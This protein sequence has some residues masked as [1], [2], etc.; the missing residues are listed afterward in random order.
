MR[1]IDECTP[2]L[3]S[4]EEAH[5]VVVTVTMTRRDQARDPAADAQSVAN[6]C[7]N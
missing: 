2:L 4:R 7:R 1:V 6:I 5:P 3:A